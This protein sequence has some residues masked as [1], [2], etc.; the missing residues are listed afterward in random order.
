MPA[1]NLLV[2]TTSMRSSMSAL[3]KKLSN[4][5]IQV[6]LF[7]A[8]ISKIEGKFDNIL[9][10]ADVYRARVERE[11]KRE[12]RR[13]EKEI[14][15]TPEKIS[16]SSPEET[17]NADL[18]VAA[19]VAIFETILRHMCGT[20]DDFLIASQ[21]FLFPSVYERIMD[22]ED[23]TYY[24][25]QVPGSAKL[26]IERGQEHISWLRQEYDTHLT[27]PSTWK[28]AIDYIVEWWRNDALPLLYGCRDEK[29]D[30]DEPLTLQEMILWKQSATER[31]L[32]FPKIFDAYEIF[33]RYKDDI[34][35][36]SGLRAFEFQLFTYE[37]SQTPLTPPRH[38]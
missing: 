25:L 36:A 1:D 11:A 10:Q 24:L 32:N 16:V 20:S 3:K 37:T 21:A 27:D 17:E 13:L 6:E 7:D 18:K 4:L 26:V 33:R 23:E 19:S 15:L 35:A 34:Y 9:T 28:D 29:W 14:T 38:N 30:A 12:I 22:G 2:A 8:E 31:T 5:K